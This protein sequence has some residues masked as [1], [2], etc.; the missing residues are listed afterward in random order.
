MVARFVAMLERPVSR[1]RLE[2]YRDGGDDLAM[3]VNYFFNLERS[4]ALSPSLQ[5]FEIA[6]CNSIDAALTRRLQMPLWFDHAGF[7][8]PWQVK[9]MT[10]F[11]GANATV[12]TSGIAST[13][14][15]CYATGSCPTSR[16]GAGPA[17]AT[18]TPASSSP[19]ERRWS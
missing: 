16:S 19:D 4:E 1:V 12:R 2:N 14:S 13:A 10:A 9:Q 7:L 18:T 17:L 5:A 15:A 6:L 11:H 3:V 8:S